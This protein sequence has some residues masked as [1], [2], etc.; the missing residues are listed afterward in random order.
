VKLDLD[1][2][3]P[4]FQTVRNTDSFS[5]ALRY[6][7]PK[8]RVQVP[9]KSNVMSYKQLAPLKDKTRF[10]EESLIFTGQVFTKLLFGQDMVYAFP[11]SHQSV[12][13]FQLQ[14]S[15]GDS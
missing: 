3:V 1:R 9:V 12:I 10:L 13:L 8:R 15:L 5:W 11:F 6:K 4:T 14:Y 7:L 2:C